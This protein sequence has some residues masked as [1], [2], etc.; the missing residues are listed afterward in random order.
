[1]IVVG[2]NLCYPITIES[3]GHLVMRKITKR[4][5]L[6]MAQKRLY[7]VLFIRGNRLHITETR[8]SDLIFIYYVDEVINEMKRGKMN[9][10]NCVLADC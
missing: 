9:M 1:M 6:M 3:L 5:H 8:V 7:S 2:S 4:I 10:Q